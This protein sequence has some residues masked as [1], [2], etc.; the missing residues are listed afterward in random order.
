MTIS[1][2]Y[3][4][5]YFKKDSTS[6]ILFVDEKFNISGLKKHISNSEYSY[7]YDLLKNKDL[8]KKIYEFEINSNK[9]IILISL[10]KNTTSS[11]MENLGA[12]F[13]DHLKEIKKS[14]FVLN[15][16][17]LP[18]KTYNFAGHF[19]HGLKL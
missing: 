14:Q 4:N 13:Y 3:K 17:T 7:I 2:N 11:E 6:L 9:K 16:D 19:L 15:S 1:I 5:N 12:K 8:K 18:T 10:K